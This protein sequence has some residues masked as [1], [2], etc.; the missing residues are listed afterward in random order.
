MTPK[1]YRT[2]AWEDRN[3]AVFLLLVW[4]LLL[5]HV[6]TE[7]TNRRPVDSFT[8]LVT[9]GLPLGS[10]YWFR[11]AARWRSEARRLSEELLARG[12]D[13]TLLDPPD[14]PRRPTLAQFRQAAI[15]CTVFGAASLVAWGYFS[16]TI[17]S[18]LR[19]H[20]SVDAWSWVA[21]VV[22]LS[23]GVAYLLAVVGYTRIRRRH[24]AE[25]ERKGGGVASPLGPTRRYRVQE[26]QRE[27]LDA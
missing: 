6:I 11:Q 7:V 22:F 20:Q 26:G 21:A 14:I 25:Q 17:L 3:S 1:R 13:S 19:A 23:C 2:R 24:R 27:L 18:T 12:F 10:A 15:A 4:V 9:L 16:L 5:A 8:W